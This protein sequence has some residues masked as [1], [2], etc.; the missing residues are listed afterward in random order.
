MISVMSSLR[1]QALGTSRYIA[2]PDG[3]ALP[4][5]ESIGGLPLQHKTIAAVLDSSLACCK[6]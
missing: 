1:L 5:K 2:I 4:D 3:C 6:A